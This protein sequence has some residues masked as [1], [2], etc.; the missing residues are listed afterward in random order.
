MAVYYTMEKTFYDYGNGY[1]EV[2]W[3]KL[4]SLEG[5]VVPNICSKSEFDAAVSDK[6]DEWWKTAERE[7]KMRH[8][9]D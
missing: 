7:E 9:S 1:V 3:G 8:S 6:R 2:I 4:K 5:S